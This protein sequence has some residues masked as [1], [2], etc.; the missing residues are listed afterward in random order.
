M[1]RIRDRAVL[2]VLAVVV[3][4][5]GAGRACDAVVLRAEVLRA[6]DARLPLVAR[7]ALERIP[8]PGRMLLAARAYFRARTSLEERWSWSE[9]QIATFKSSPQQQRLLA[10]IA[11]VRTAFE[12]AHPGHSLYVHDTVRSLDRQID[13]WNGNDSVGRSGEALLAELAGSA[14]AC[15]AGS[16]PGRVEALWSWLSRWTP[17]PRPNLA[18]PGLSPHG[19]ARAIDF[20]I[21]N[22]ADGRIVAAADSRQIET[23]WRAEGWDRRLADAVT[24]SGAPFHGPLLSPDEPWHYEHLE[25]PPA[26][27][28]GRLE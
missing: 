3:L 17:Q 7:E 11:Q 6:L 20:Q 19:R 23:V 8:D 26:G 5:P 16:D 13:A 28:D 25:R 18:A 21:A 2:L 22:E 27:G 14:D 10:D 12:A 9:A 15:P 4:A 24:V 1:S